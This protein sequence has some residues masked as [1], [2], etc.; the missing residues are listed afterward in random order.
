MKTHQ[1]LPA[2][3]YIFGYEFDMKN[4][5]ECEHVKFKVH[6]FTKRIKPESKKIILITS[7][8]EMGCETL[9]PL[10]CMPRLIR[11]NPNCYFIVLG[12]FG[13][14]YLYQHL[15][16]EFWELDDTYSWMRTYSYAFVN[17]SK[18]YQKI[19]DSIKIE[20]NVISGDILGH[21]M[22]GT[23]CNDCGHY[24]GSQD[25]DTKCP[26]CRSKDVDK[27]IFSDVS[28]SRKSVV[29]IPSPRKE[30][31]EWAD[32]LIGKNTVGIFARKRKLY[33]RNLPIEFYRN[34]VTSLHEK[35]YKVVWL[36]E[37][38]SIHDC[39]SNMGIVDFSSMPES[40]DLEKTLAIISKCKFTIQYW[41]AST[42]LAGITN[43]PFIIFESPGQILPCQAQEAHRICLTSNYDKRKVVL[44]SF[45]LALN[46]LDV[47]L[48]HTNRAIDNLNK[49]NFN[50][51]ISL[52]DYPKT[53]HDECKNKLSFWV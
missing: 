31:V 10:Y 26:N 24:Y 6:K 9:I 5:A 1:L 23:T 45:D 49:N 43:T 36:G 34:L 53:I 40:Y 18:V 3:K 41:T 19:L 2:K 13:R 11:N 48:K 7:F 35:N 33:N 50:I 8:G 51:E 4:D 47:V 30:Y 15:A 32:N 52:V 37:K 14:S 12:F 16:D 39:P 21:I 22:V 20:G 38:G 29:N 17:L 27:S 44:C 46:N 28:K 25:Q 42:R